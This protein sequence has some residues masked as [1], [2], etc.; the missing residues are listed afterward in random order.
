MKLSN[1]GIPN[2]MIYKMYPEFCTM[3]QC[4]SNGNDSESDDETNDKDAKL[5]NEIDYD[6]DED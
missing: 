6:S 4:D 1:D 5:K 3:M 2:K